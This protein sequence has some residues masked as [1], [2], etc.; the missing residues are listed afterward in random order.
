MAETYKLELYASGPYV[1]CESTEVVDL[2]DYGYSDEDWD[3]EPERRQEEL[4][5]EW[6]EEFFWNEGYEYNAKV[7]R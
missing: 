4:L 7:E 2:S 1:G 6:G 3:A 5:S